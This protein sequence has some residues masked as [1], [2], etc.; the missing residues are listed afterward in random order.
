MRK[1][2]SA[3]IVSLLFNVPRLLPTLSL[4]A[5]QIPDL[6]FGVIDNFHFTDGTPTCHLGNA[7]SILGLLLGD[8]GSVRDFLPLRIFQQSLSVAPPTIFPVMASQK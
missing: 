5:C 6:N 1:P 7:F 3:V 8:F 2:Q 4:V